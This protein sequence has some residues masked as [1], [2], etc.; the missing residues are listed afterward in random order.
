MR[1]FYFHSCR[2]LRLVVLEIILLCSL[3]YFRAAKMDFLD[4]LD[5]LDYVLGVVDDGEDVEGGVN[6]VNGRRRE[7][8]MYTRK[9]VDD[10]DEKDFR[11]YFRL[12]KNTFWHLHSLVAPMIEGDNRR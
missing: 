2:D 9:T 3:F 5:D 1:F 7:Y 4:Y 6:G 11:R 8:R 12:A 10:F